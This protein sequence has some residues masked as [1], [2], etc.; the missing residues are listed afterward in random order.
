MTDKQISRYNELLLKFIQ[1]DDFHELLY[2]TNNYFL[3]MNIVAKKEKTLFID[4]P[5]ERLIYD[6]ENRERMLKEGGNK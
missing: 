2:L 5:Y 4:N 1:D 6:L 3:S